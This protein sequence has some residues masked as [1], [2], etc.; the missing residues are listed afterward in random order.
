MHILHLQAAD[1][2]YATQEELDA[3]GITPDQIPI[4]QDLKK[5]KIMA[6]QAATVRETRYGD[7]AIVINEAMTGDGKSL[8]GQFDLFSLKHTTFTMYPTNELANDQR[9]ALNALMERWTPPQ[10]STR[11]LIPEVINAAKL[12]ELE[13]ALEH[14]SRPEVLRLATNNDLILTN[15][16]VF[17]LIMSFGYNQHG[18]ARDRLLADLVNSFRLFVFDEFHLFGA[19]QSA[20]VMIAMLLMREIAPKQR[21][22]RFLF[23]SATPQEMLTALAGKIGLSVRR[24]AG[25]Y[26][27]GLSVAS[28]GWRRILQPATLTLYPTRLEAW[29]KEHTD[30]VILPFYGENAPGAKG[31]IIVNGVATAY[32]VLDLLKAPCA[33]NNIRLGENTGVTPHPERHIDA[34]LLVATST[35]DVGV[36]FRINFMVFESTDAANHMQRLG[37]LGRHTDDGAKHE[38]SRFEAHAMLPAW[39]VD[40][41]AAKFPA[42]SDIDREKYKAALHEVFP[43]LQEFRQYIN[44][45][46]GVQAAHVLRELRKPEIRT[47]YASIQERLK[48]Q[49]RVL[50]PGGAGKYNSLAHDEQFATLDEARS[51]RGG[52]PFTALVQR[53]DSRTQEFVSYNLITLLLN[54]KLE[55]IPDDEAD[56]LMRRMNQNIKALQ[57]SHPLGAF[58]L[59]DWLPKPRPV[60]VYID[61]ELGTEHFEVVLELKRVRLNA[62]DVLGMRHINRALETRTIP[63]LLTK[64]EPEELR[65]KLKLGYQLEMFTFTSVGT[66]IGTVAFARDALLLDSVLWRKK[67]SNN[68]PIIS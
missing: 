52:S 28:E 4:G 27:H 34:D 68:D 24:I 26:Q 31:A 47:Q 42:N 33:A 14:L 30:D 32:R 38:F 21:P 53:I 57:R 64:Q 43:P 22:P 3:A 15:P 17:N 50:F 65:R 29:I 41:L 35:V 18:I 49:Y 6:H 20:A 44:R 11:Q 25:E 60:D 61:Q 59:H 10:W 1:S 12:D 48:E 63:A 2:R 9:R 13:E 36:D 39:V 67:T 40:G 45:W 55:Y 37:R 5:M 8:A 62:P 51:F 16:D 56:A 54:G 7:A 58:R 66:A 23:L 46:A 19:P